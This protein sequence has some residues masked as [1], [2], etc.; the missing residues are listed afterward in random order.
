MFTKHTDI[1]HPCKDLSSI[2][3]IIFDLAFSKIHLV[4]LSLKIWL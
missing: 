1:T 4:V 2:D 3:S